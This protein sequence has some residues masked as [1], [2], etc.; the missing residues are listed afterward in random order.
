M[1]IRIIA[2]L[3]PVSI[4]TLLNTAIIVATRETSSGRS[5]VGRQ[6]AW[7]AVGWFL[8]VVI[9]GACGIHGDITVPVI[10]CIILWLIAAVLIAVDKTLPLSPPEWW[11]HTKIG[12]MAIP[13]SA[14]RKYGL[15]IAALTIVAVI[16]G[17]FWSVID[18]YQPLHLVHLDKADAPLVIK[19]AIA[20]KFFIFYSTLIS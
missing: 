4:I 10:I 15:E 2:D 5:D 18:T 8:F 1:L 20:S 3:F 17:G 19:L 13:L 7:G 9:L 6:L 12:M 16:L 11:W 14:I